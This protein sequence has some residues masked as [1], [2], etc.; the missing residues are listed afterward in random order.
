MSY[1]EAARKLPWWC[2]LCE[3]MHPIG[4]HTE[5]G[6]S[7]PPSPPAP[8][9]PPPD[10]DYYRCSCGLHLFA[11]EKTTSPAIWARHVAHIRAF[12]QE[13][14]RLIAG[15][16]TAWG[17]PDPGSGP[18]ALCRKQCQRY[19]DGGKPLCDACRKAQP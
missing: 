11:T 9:R 12:Q 14:Q 8:P 19:G 5:P 17:L 2:E 10:P 15:A 18:C 3:R 16:I 4:K 7:W 6:V 1:I 13:T